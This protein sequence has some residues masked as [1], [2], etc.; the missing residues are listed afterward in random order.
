MSPLAGFNYLCPIDDL[1]PILTFECS[2][3]SF[4]YQTF[5]VYVQYCNGWRLHLSMKHNK[6]TSSPMWT[7]LKHEHLRSPNCLTQHHSAQLWVPSTYLSGFLH[8]CAVGLLSV[9][10]Q[11][12]WWNEGLVHIRRLCV[13]S[14]GLH[15]RQAHSGWVIKK[16]TRL[17]LTQRNK[18]KW[19][20]L[21]ERTRL[22]LQ[23]LHQ[24]ERS[25][26]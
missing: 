15:L 2:P 6:L 26:S 9:W 11:C 23:L 20:Q 5:P 17:H 16:N 14:Q 8:R 12:T 22:W 1:F 24:Q 10:T 25:E 19:A 7:R 21:A 3:H 4:N 18:K 13:P